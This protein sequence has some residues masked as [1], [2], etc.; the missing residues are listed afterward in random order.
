MDEFDAER[1]R[2]AQAKPEYVVEILFK[3]GVWLAL[4]RVTEFAVVRAERSGKV[5]SLT[6]RQHEGA[7]CKLF[8]PS[9]DLSEVVAVVE[10]RP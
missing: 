6:C 10:R 7:K 5:V 9:I 4:D 8:V 3:S 1:E 2:L